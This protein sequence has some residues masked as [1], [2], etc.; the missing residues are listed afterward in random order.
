MATKTVTIQHYGATLRFDDE[1]R[2]EIIVNA[3]LASAL[4][5][6]A[7]LVEATPADTGRA[8]AGWITRPTANGAETSN[9]SPVIGILELGSRPH[10]PPFRPILEWVVRKFGTGKRSFEN[11]SE[12]D[13]ELMAIAWGT[14]RKIQD[15]GTQPHFMVKKNLEKLARITKRHVERALG[16]L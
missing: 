2:R 10:R 14:V 3:L 12:V 13:P 5:G 8:R 16:V 1:E 15:H 6:E 11:Y 9:D 4:T 7:L